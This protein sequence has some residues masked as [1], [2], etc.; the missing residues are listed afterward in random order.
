MKKTLKPNGPGRCQA[1]LLTA[2]GHEIATATWKNERDQWKELVIE[3]TPDQVSLRLVVDSQAPV[4]VAVEGVFP[5]ASA[6]AQHFFAPAEAV[7]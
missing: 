6:S 4:D 1:T 7:R 2:D 5:F 3:R